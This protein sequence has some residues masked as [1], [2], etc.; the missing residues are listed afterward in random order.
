MNKAIGGGIPAEL[1]QNLKDDA[2]KVLHSL[3]FGLFKYLVDINLIYSL[4]ETLSGDILI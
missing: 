4:Y 2:M 1:F 3:S